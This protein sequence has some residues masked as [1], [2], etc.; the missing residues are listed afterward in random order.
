MSDEYIVKLQLKRL[1]NKVLRIFLYK[2][3]F[4]IHIYF[5]QF[6]HVHE[7]IVLKCMRFIKKSI[8]I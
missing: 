7:G 6:L 8:M 3:E 4:K 5:A 2:I 1:L